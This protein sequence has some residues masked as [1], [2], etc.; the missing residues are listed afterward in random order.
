LH[1][2][3]LPAAY[4]AYPRFRCDAEN[5]GNRETSAEGLTRDYTVTYYH[6]VADDDAVFKALADPTRRGLL[7]RLFE[8]DGR[9]LRELTDEQE[10]TR[11]GVMKHLRVLEEA[12]LVVARRSGREKRHYLNPV[13]IKLIHDRWIEKY[14]EPYASTLADLKRDLEEDVTTATAATVQVYQVFI[15]ATAQAIWDGITKPEF[16]SKYFHGT[17]VETTGEAG[18][19]I[20]YYAADRTSLLCDDVVIESDPPHRLVTTWHALWSEETAAED[21]S[22]VTWEIEEQDGGVCLLRVT[23]DKLENSPKTAESVSGGWM[24]IISGLKTLL[25][26]GEPMSA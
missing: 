18:T 23:H 6:V 8:R 25:E 19:P 5:E 24:H 14:R 15:K 12:G 16:T 20:R 22:R 13:P 2:S 26:T 21:A 10:M 3:V 7:D 1:S 17:L 4:S 11:F 9:T